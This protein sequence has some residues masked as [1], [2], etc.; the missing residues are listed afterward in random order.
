MST[1]LVTASPEHETPAKDSF[2]KSQ[3]EGRIGYFEGELGGGYWGAGRGGGTRR[4][5]VIRSR[6]KV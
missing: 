6:C 1:V 2:W 5:G 3:V 4:I